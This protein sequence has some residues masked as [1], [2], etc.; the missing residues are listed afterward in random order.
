MPKPLLFDQ[1]FLT[2]LI[3]YSEHSA[4]VRAFLPNKGRISLFCQG[5]FKVSPKKPYTLQAPGFAKISYWESNHNSL[6]KL[7]DFNLDPNLHIICSSLKSIG[8]FAYIAE[9]IEIMI[10][11]EDPAPSIYNDSLSLYKKLTTVGAHPQFLRAFELKLLAHA[12]FLPELIFE[13]KITAFDYLQ[14]Q[15][16]EKKSEN[17]VPFSVEGIKMA[18]RL[19]IDPIDEI[20]CNDIHLLRMIGRLFS[21]RLKL[22]GKTNL[23]SIAF[24]KNIT[25]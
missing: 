14:S 12:G 17:S 1:A 5:A 15:F 24:L 22:L 6:D 11:E 8:Y 16:L 20:F 10:P 7:I 21:I 19:L 13:E 4:I 2:S 23:K 18:R 9:I 25:N 3:P